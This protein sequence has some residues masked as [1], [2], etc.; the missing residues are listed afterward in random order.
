MTRRQ[1]IVLTILA[2]LILSTIIIML[3]TFPVVQTP[4]NSKEKASDNEKVIAFIKNVLPIDIS[5][6][7]ISLKFRN[8]EEYQGYPRE[9]GQYLLEAENST[10]DIIYTYE[11]NVLWQ[12]SMYITKGSVISDRQYPNITDAAT[13]FLLKY[14]NYTHIDLAEMITMLTNV[15]PNTNMTITSGNLKLTVTYQALSNTVFGDAAN[16]RW[17]R[18]FNGC[19]YTALDLSFRNGIFSG[20]VDHTQLYSIGNTAVNLSMQQATEIALRYTKNYSYYLGNGIWISNFGVIGTSATLI[21]QE[22][23]PRSEPYVVYPCW[24][25]KVFFDKTYPGSVD[26]LIVWIWA[27]SGEIL[28]T[29]HFNYR[30]PQEY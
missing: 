11:N 23:R 13:W 20:L 9:I 15:D 17:V 24:I 1:T 8:S 26:G 27:D 12:C 21:P 29:S 18:T 30:W 19:D 14:Q 7:N 22:A 5:C 4:L 2:S 25:V 6:Y 16:F 28:T 10:L 3:A